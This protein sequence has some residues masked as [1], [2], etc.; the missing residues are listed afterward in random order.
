[1]PTPPW[2]TPLYRPEAISIGGLVT[3][4]NVGASYD[5]IAAARGLGCAY[6]DMTNVMSIDFRVMCNKV[7]TGTQDWQLWNETDAAEVGVISDAGAA[8]N[9]TLSTTFSGLALTGKKLLRVRARS[10]T[11]A[12]DPVYYG[13]CITLN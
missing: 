1:M 7:G 13:S 2:L 4:T 9:K 6:V 3:L 12:D 11:A 8:G 5:T 10:S